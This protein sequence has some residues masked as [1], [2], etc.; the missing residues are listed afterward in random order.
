MRLYL[1]HFIY[2][3]FYFLKTKVFLKVFQNLHLI[4]SFI[5]L[6][7]FYHLKVNLI[8]NL[9]KKYQRFNVFHQMISITLLMKWSYWMKMMSYHLYPHSSDSYHHHFHLHSL[10]ICFLELSSTILFR[11]KH[12]LLL[13]PQ[14]NQIYHLHHHSHFIT[15][16]AL[17]PIHKIL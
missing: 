1:N 7:I 15:S 6:L 9:S 11:I 2:L 16:K 12:Q 3:L 4:N 17:F 5:L 8:I 10:I 13:I 14:K